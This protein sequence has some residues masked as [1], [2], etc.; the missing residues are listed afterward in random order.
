MFLNKH[1]Y[2]LSFWQVANMIHD[3]IYKSYRIEVL[4][5]SNVAVN[6]RLYSVRIMFL[7]FWWNFSNGDVS[8]G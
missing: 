2:S 3:R 7:C 5:H 6:F 8:P 1:A 4:T